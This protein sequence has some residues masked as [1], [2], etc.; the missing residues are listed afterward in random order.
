L[1]S[2][3]LV[4]PVKVV[5]RNEVPFG[6]DT[7]VVQNNTITHGSSQWASPS[8]GWGELAVGTR[9]SQRCCPVP[10]YLGLRCRIIII[11]VVVVMLL[12]LIRVVGIDSDSWS[13]PSGCADSDCTYR[14]EWSLNAATDII[15]FTISAKQA[16]DRWTGIAFA[17]NTSMVFD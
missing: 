4:R 6:G 16:Q 11:V 14:A 7:R 17:S 15:T 3:T 2:V 12:K 10:N 13:W 5:G 1:S 9:S 8:T